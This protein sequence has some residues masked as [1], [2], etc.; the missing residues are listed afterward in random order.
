MLLAAPFPYGAVY[1]WAWASI[2]VLTLLIVLLWLLGSIQQGWMK[3]NYS[4]LYVPAALLL[5]IGVAQLV[6]HHTVAAV[7][8]REAVLKLGTY[9]LL[10][11]VVIQL[12]AEAPVTT[13]RRAG[14]GVLGFGFAFSFLSILQFLWS[15]GRIL[16]VERNLTNAFGTY[17]DH[18]HYA[19]LMEMIVPLAA[20]YVLS[21]PKRD[22]LKGILWFAVA[23]PIVSLLLT[24]SRGGL[25]AI[26]AEMAVL[27][28]ILIRRSPHSD[29]RVQVVTTG[30]ALA[31]AA[32]LFLWLVPAYTLAR[33]GSVNAY[34][35]EAKEGR[36]ALWK[37]SLGI[38]AE[39][40]ILGSGLGTF[41]TAFPAHQSKPQSLITEHAHN[42]YVEALTDGGLLGE[43]AVLAAVFIFLQTAFRHLEARL[44]HETGWL[45]L[46]AAIACCG[47]L[48]HS[49]VDFNLQIPANTAW[50]A[51]CAGLAA[52]SART[53]AHR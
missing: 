28:S 21:R 29:R 46:G 36:P 3:I 31:G 39:Y 17:V 10:F 34:T 37:D 12:F 48:V 9:L 24:G 20:A 4:P 53:V 35:T 40:P 30:L 23:V 8:T 50:F 11:Y 22:P 16:W 2:T 1:T 19:G 15:P 27:G 14:V 7:S 44:R 52:L 33:M 38:F 42:D 25:G 49:F 51:F 18:D 6:L 45:E 13:W 41:V 43:F 32:A 26:L 5:A 47:L